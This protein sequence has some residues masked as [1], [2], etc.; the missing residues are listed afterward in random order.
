MPSL[1]ERK[2]HKTMIIVRNRDEENGVVDSGQIVNFDYCTQLT[3][4]AAAD[5]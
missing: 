4:V 3:Y 5:S 2:C 1:R